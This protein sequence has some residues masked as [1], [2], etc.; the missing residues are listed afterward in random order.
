MKK[1]ILTLLALAPSFAF[2]GVKEEVAKIDST[3]QACLNSP[4]GQSTVGMKECTG[5]AFDSADKL[6]NQEYSAYVATLKKKSGDPLTDK[7]DAETL[8]RLVASEKA[9]VAFRDTNSSLAGTT[10]LGGTGEGLVIADTAYE[11]T[12]A[13]V[14]ELNTLINGNN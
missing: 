14:L 6:L 7:D 2:A 5:A 8:R 1:V 3:L 9:W 10:M 4:D 13:R 11:M 12:K